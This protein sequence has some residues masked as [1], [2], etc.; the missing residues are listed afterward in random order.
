MEIMEFAL[1]NT[2]ITDRNDNLWLQV[3]GIP[4]GDP[5]SPG[6]T[7]GTCAWME[8]EWLNTLEQE[9]RDSFVARRYMD[10]VIFFVAKNGEID[11]DK[12]M[13]NFREECYWPD[14]ENTGKHA[15]TRPRGTRSE[16]ERLIPSRNPDSPGYQVSVCQGRG[17][18]SGH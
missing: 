12:L 9:V 10:D 5:H 17:G 13:N 3:Q 8:K 6:I 15:P 18:F 11:C 14:S 2:M 16:P 4:M 1:H 7:I